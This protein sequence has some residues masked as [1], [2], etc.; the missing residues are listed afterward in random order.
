MDPLAVPVV[1]L[2]PRYGW[3]EGRQTGPDLKAERR[4]TVEAWLLGIVL[5]LPAALS[6]IAY[7]ATFW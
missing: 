3:R 1:R 5:G 2:D 6:V 4:L 7:L